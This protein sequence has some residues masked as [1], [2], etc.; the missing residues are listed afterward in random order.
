MTTEQLKSGS[1][2]CEEKPPFSAAIESACV[3]HAR[4]RARYVVTYT[5]A[6]E[7]NVSS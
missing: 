1:G 7:I 3:M 6:H 5:H 4:T 2:R